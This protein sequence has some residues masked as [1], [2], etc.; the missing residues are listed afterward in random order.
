MISASAPTLAAPATP[1]EVQACVRDA[2]ARSSSISL[3][4]ANSDLSPLR[5]DLSRL[6]GWRFW[7]PD[8]LTCGV[9]SGLSPREL[10]LRLTERNLFLP[11]DL[12]NPNLSLGAALAGHHSG[13]LRQGYGSLR[14]F[15]IGIEFVTGMGEL[16][17]AGGRVVKNVA[18]Y[19]LMKLMIGSRGSFGIITAVNF[20]LFPAP[21]PTVTW[22]IPCS[23]W[24]AAARF[25]A[26]LL[27][28]FLKPIAFELASFV[29]AEYAASAHTQL[30]IIVRCAGDVPVHR[31]YE[32]ELANF[33]GQIQSHLVAIPADRENHFWNEWNAW[34]ASAPI[35][36]S[37]PGALALR[38]LPRLAEH[39]RASGLAFDFQGRL[40]LGVYR[41]ALRPGFTPD[42]LLSARAMLAE[43]GEAWLAVPG[44]ASLDA[45]G[46]LATSR[47]FLREL[48]QQLD[49]HRILP[50]PFGLTADNM[51][52]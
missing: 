3:D 28:S 39:A 31:R 52:S 44:D 33:A 36:Y 19:D 6:R 43:L 15:V 45:W 29:S 48:K 11:L 1:A 22:L 4:P 12:P 2:I 7:E 25:R 27:A 14:D 30:W 20:R 37:A 40:G 17:K 46:P 42:W 18:G 50:D 13:P 21:A 23:G 49:P 10:Q 34:P 9:E 24:D 51:N 5:L 38:A 35:R 8:D 41:L 26:A 47:E 32:R 16:V